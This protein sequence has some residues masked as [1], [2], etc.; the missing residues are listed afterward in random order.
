MALDFE[1]HT[2]ASVFNVAAERWPNNEVFALPSDPTR[3]YYP[4]GYG[5]SFSDARHHVA[6]YE[7]ALLGSGYGNGHRI[8]CLLANRP[9]IMWL[10]LAMNGIGISWV[11]INPDYRPSELAY[12]L[13]DSAADL[14]VVGSEFLDLAQE[15][16]EQNDKKTPILVLSEN[17]TPPAPKRPP[18]LNGTPTP[19]G[20]ASLLYTSGTTGR[21][22]GCILSHEYELSVGHWYAEIGGRLSIREGVERVYNP[23]P[24][25]HLNAAV[26]LFFGMVLTGN[27]H[28]ST[29][30]FSRSRWWDEISETRA[31]GCHYLGI[32]VPSLMNEP[33][34]PKDHEHGLRWGA[35]AGV[36]PSLHRPFEERFG[37][38]LI[39]LWGMTEFCR[40]LTDAYEPRSID[41]R[42]MGRPRPGLDVRV[43]DENNIDVPIGT[44]GEMVV[45]HSAETPRRH[46]FSGYLNLPEETEKAWLG[47][48]FHTGDTVTQDES[49][50]LY[51][52]DRKKN[53]IRRSGENIAAAEI[54]ACLQPLDE[55]DAIAVMPIEDE[56]RDEEV[57]ACIVANGTADSSL[58]QRLFNH[59]FEHLAY[60]KAPGW[61]LF[62]DAIPVT[63]TQKIQKHMI[64][65]PTEDPRQRPDIHD[66]RH[67]KRR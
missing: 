56:L 14:L 21:P 32:V 34:S 28:I 48:W 44:P 1:G 26:V 11:P 49:G 24:L 64:F 35:G 54:E 65:E 2:T 29:A 41:T 15:A 27:C 30:R 47:G 53:I 45:R 63:G 16:Q 55:V 67:L 39:E 51:F 4:E 10:K 37:F 36:E 59:C 42:A 13:R 33:P 23:L 5:I 3:P 66:F 46:A 43:V 57:L 62:L 31:T 50:M 38:P 60:F 61:I 17:F 18:P 12:V 7:A 6:N 19:D 22:K 8:A 40:V 9:E 25:F 58:A 20:E 52:V